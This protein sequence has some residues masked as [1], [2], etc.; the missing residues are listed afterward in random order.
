MIN[1]DKLHSFVEEKLGNE[2]SGHDYAHAL[3]VLENARL[4]SNTLDVDH[5][6][7]FVSALVHD[8]ID[9]K[10]ESQYRSSKEE[11]IELL[12]SVQ[13]DESFIDRLFDIIE[14]MSFRKGEV[15]DSVEGQLVQ[16]A[17]RLDAL[18]AIGIARTFAFGGAKHRSILD[19]D[20]N[21]ETSVGHFYDKLFTLTDLM[22]SKEA[23]TEAENRTRFMKEFIEELQR[24][25]GIKEFR[26]GAHNGKL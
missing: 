10:L 15:L 4:I 21:K 17:D 1:Y 22:N 11:V 12:Q 13:C 7:I 26:K 24:E 18:G 16:D 6:L 20:D 19:H 14:H 5:D 25:T 9:D 23:K 3:R 8:L 2:P